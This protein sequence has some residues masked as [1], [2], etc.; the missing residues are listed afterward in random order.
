[1]AT[2]R[3]TASYDT[4]CAVRACSR[5]GRRESLCTCVK[6]MPPYGTRGYRKARAQLLNE[7]TVC[8]LCGGSGTADDPL[9]ADHVLEVAAGGGSN[10]V[11][12]RAAHLSCNSRRGQSFQESAA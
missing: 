11:E 6:V 12:M 3:T 9:T 10:R 2:W 8:W 1:V 4:L 5:C 7:E